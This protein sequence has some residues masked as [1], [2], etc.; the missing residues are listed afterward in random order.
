M[1]IGHENDTIK[2][3]FDSCEISSFGAP[4]TSIVVDMVTSNGEME[5][6]RRV[7]LLGVNMATKL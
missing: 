7:R 6:M 2:K 1:S 4:I 5:M 3:H